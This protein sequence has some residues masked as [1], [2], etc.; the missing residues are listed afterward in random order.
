MISKRIAFLL[1]ITL[2]VTS[3]NAS[4]HQYFTYILLNKSSIKPL[5]KKEIGVIEGYPKLDETNC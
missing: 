5:F 3:I 4:N 1:F 2:I